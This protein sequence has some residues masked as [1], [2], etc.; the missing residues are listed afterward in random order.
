M[1]S[2]GQY[3]ALRSRKWVTRS[4]FEHR[5][6]AS[7]CL[8]LLRVMC[9]FMISIGTPLDVCA[10][11]PPSHENP[12]DGLRIV[13][14]KNNGLPTTIT[15][16]GWGSGLAFTITA[17][18]M[19]GTLGGVAPNFTYAPTVGYVGS[20]RFSFTRANAAGAS[21]TV[22]LKIMVENPVVA[23]PDDSSNTEDD[24]KKQLK[25][26]WTEPT[27]VQNVLNAFQLLVAAPPPDRLG[28]KVLVEL[29]GGDPEAEPAHVCKN[30]RT[31]SERQDT[32][33]AALGDPGDDNHHGEPEINT[34]IN[35]VDDLAKANTLEL[36]APLDEAR[37]FACTDSLIGTIYRPPAGFAPASQLPGQIAIEKIDELFKA[38][39]SDTA[40]YQLLDAFPANDPGYIEYLEDLRAA[41]EM[42]TKALAAQVA[43]KTT[44]KKNQQ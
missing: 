10:E 9:A 20:D 8:N 26:E 24:A 4:Y 16:L 29:G 18:P 6:F 42:D 31:R 12:C 34:G 21:E 3:Q 1:F 28:C 41:F 5:V 35:F 23:A 38:G 19:H 40:V 11:V 2:T 33:R 17:A 25:A 32:Y 37:L 27:H 39:D 7:D 22:E 44:G 14:A 13:K 15:V 43:K 30:V 36:K